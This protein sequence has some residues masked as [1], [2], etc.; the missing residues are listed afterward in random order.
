MLRVLLICSV[1]LLQSCYQ[2]SRFSVYPAY[3]GETRLVNLGLSQQQVSA[4][5]ELAYQRWLGTPYRYGHQAPG[6]GADCSGFTQHVFEDQFSIR[7]PRTTREQIERGQ[8][9]S[10][11]NART[12]DLVF[13]NLGNGYGHV[14]IYLENNIVM[15]AT[16]SMGVTKTDLN[17]NKW[18]A[19]RVFRVKR[20][21]L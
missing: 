13:F 1:L 16:S 19:K 7:L 3:I 4:K 15:Q 14:A 6:L 17:S 18:W 20:I 10:L 2:V 9:V 11:K 8:F 12:G 5:L 21:I